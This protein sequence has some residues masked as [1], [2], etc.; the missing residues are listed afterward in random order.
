SSGLLQPPD[1]TD[2]P[3]PDRG[4]LRDPGAGLAVDAAG[5]LCAA[6]R[7]RVGQRGVFRKYRLAVAVRL[8]RYR[9]RQEAAAASL[10]ARH[11]RAILPV[12]AVDA[13]AGCPPAPEYARRG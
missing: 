7:R 3:G 6:K 10:V 4:A 8:F 12:L 9:I 1:Q 13:D 5:G 2:L 11:R